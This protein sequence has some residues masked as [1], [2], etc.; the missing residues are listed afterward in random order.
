VK[1]VMFAPSLMYN[2]GPY[3]FNAEWLHGRLTTAAATGA[4]TNTNGD[5]FAMSVIFKF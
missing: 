1:N 5:Q 3:G 2:M 4:E